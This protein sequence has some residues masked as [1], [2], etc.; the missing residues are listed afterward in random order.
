MVPT[1]QTARIIVP[2]TVA[3]AAGDPVTVPPGPCLL[4][5]INSRIVDL[6]WGAT[7]QKSARFPVEELKSA[8]E[9]GD[10]VL[11]D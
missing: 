4:E 10:L 7:G 11:L 8:A 3:G 1:T 9:R 2:I 6:I 5:R